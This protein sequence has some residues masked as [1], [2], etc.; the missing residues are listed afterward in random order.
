MKRFLQYLILA[1]VL[2]L[3]LPFF[4]FGVIRYLK[5]EKEKEDE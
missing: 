5:I 2:V 3:A 1:V 4:V